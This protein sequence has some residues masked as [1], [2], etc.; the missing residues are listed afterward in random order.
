MKSEKA[1]LRLFDAISKMRKILSANN[2]ASVNVEY[3]MEDYD[4]IENVTREE[5]ETLLAP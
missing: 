5:F 4:M 3:L 2:E 1:R